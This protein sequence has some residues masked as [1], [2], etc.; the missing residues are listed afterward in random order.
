MGSEVVQFVFDVLQA[1][2]QCERANGQVEPPHAAAVLPALLRCCARRLTAHPGRRRA[3]AAVANSFAS[4]TASG[5]GPYLA[6]FRIGVMFGIILVLWVIQWV[7][8]RSLQKEWHR[9]FWRTSTD[10]ATQGL[11]CCYS[12]SQWTDSTIPR[13]FLTPIPSVT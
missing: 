7:W 4:T 5:F 1:S 9:W 2:P 8:Q 13:C 10:Q 11:G 3:P 6:L 12:G